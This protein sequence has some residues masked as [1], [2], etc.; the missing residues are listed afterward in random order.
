MRH[1]L[2]SFVEGIVQYRLVVA[3]ALDNDPNSEVFFGTSKNMS[4]RRVVKIL[5]LINGRYKGNFT[6]RGIISMIVFPNYE[7]VLVLHTFLISVLQSAC[8]ITCVQHIVWF[9]K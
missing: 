1:C 5:Y 9:N 7:L 6:Y 2:K 8:L 4:A 3:P